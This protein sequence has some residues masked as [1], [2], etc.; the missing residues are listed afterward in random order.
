MKR[1][2]SG[3]TIGMIGHFPFAPE[4]KEWAGTFKVIEKRP[5]EDDLPAEAG[6]DYLRTC[7]AVIITGVTLLNDTLPPVLRAAEKAW[8]LMLGPTVPMHPL[9][10]D[11]GVD[12]LTGIICAHEEQYWRELE[13]GAIVP[14]FR[15]SKPVVLSRER[16]ELPAGD[17]RERLCTLID[18]T[19]TTM[20]SLETHP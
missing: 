9:L 15:G 4:I 3:A 2:F 12:A 8:K 6:W 5:I 18:Q 17:F 13:E 1:R 16:L 20:K 11:L 14:R 7:D 19:T 10:L